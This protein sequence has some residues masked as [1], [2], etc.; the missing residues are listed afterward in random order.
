MTDQWTD[1]VRRRVRCRTSLPQW[2][3]LPPPADL[4]SDKPRPRHG[5]NAVGLALALISLVGVFLLPFLHHA[6]VLPLMA[7][8]L[9]ITVA[10]RGFS[11]GADRAGFAVL[12]GARR[13][14]DVLGLFAA[15]A[16]AFM[17]VPFV[18]QMMSD[19][20]ARESYTCWYQVGTVE[21][22]N[23]VMLCI[24][25][26]DLNRRV[27]GRGMSWSAYRMLP[28]AGNGRGLAFEPMQRPASQNFLRV[29]SLRCGPAEPRTVLIR[30][31][32]GRGRAGSKIIVGLMTSWSVDMRGDSSGHEITQ[33]RTVK[34]ASVHCHSQTN[35]ECGGHNTRLLSAFAVRGLKVLL[36][37]GFG[38]RVVH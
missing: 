9:G 23:A 8:V 20:A 6:Q 29:S 16:A 38:R 2:R 12:H 31:S 17:A 19:P 32:P 37:R 27:V 24:I 4:G 34:V 35:R 28:H 33:R 10:R 7:M 26:R 25:H 1:A 13:G 18:L 14:L 21:Q 11:G 36:A 5:V 3:S 22:A 30:A 15:G